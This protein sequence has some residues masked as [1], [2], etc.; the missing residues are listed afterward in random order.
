MTGWAVETLL[1][2]TLLMLFVLAVRR[3]VRAAVGA[4][5]AYALW[6]IPAAR[7]AMPSLPDGWRGAMMPELP[8]AADG[9]IMLGE[10]VLALPAAPATGIGWPVV[11]LAVW[12]AGAL[13]LFAWHAIGYWH[14]CRRLRRGTRRRHAVAD[15]RIAVIETSEAPG[16]LAFGILNPTIALPRDFADRY[17][18]TER[19]LAMAHE[20]GHHL[21]GDLFANWIAITVLAFHWFNPVAWRAFRAFRTDQEMACDET[22]LA[23]RGSAIRHAYAR[24]IVKSANGA[25]LSVACHMHT[26]DDLKGRLRMLGRKGA[27]A[28]QRLGGGAGLTMLALAGLALTAS[29]TRAAERMRVQVED[30]TGVDF[31]ALDEAVVAAFD[32]PEPPAAPRPPRLPEAPE[33]PQAPGAVEA[34]PPPPAPPVARRYGRTRGE[35]IILS[36]NGSKVVLHEGT[37]RVFEGGAEVPSINRRDCGPGDAVVLHE[38]EGDARV[39]VVCAD[40]LKAQSLAADRAGRDAA[41][42]GREAARQGREAARRARAAGLEAAQAGRDAARAAGLAEAERSRAYAEAERSRAFAERNRALAEGNAERNRALAEANAER[43]RALAEGN[44][45]RAH[46]LAEAGRARA[47]AQAA[48]SYALAMT[49]YAGA[50]AQIHVEVNRRDPASARAALQRARREVLANEGLTPAARDRWLDQIQA[51]LER[52]DD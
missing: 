29:G 17:D 27:S 8:P 30:A 43:N 26:V 4:R 12:V 2:S 24:A 13:A 20:L 21:R 14:F 49:A 52:L 19:N 39:A 11:L 5:V 9:V 34:P 32:L 31:A 15:G 51:R 22:V 41:R 16:P 10:P 6:A 28:R 50:D 1:S 36:D 25:S 40:R 48:R 42:A 3:P 18:A 45:E 38:G 23:S 35:H 37:A 7:L 46:A 47:D 33:E 44:A